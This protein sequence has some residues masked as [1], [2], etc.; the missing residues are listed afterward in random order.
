MYFNSSCSRVWLGTSTTSLSCIFLNSTHP[1]HVLIADGVPWGPVCQPSQRI[2]VKTSAPSSKSMSAGVLNSG[3]AN[4]RSDIWSHLRETG[5]GCRRRSLAIFLRMYACTPIFSASSSTPETWNHTE[6]RIGVVIPPTPSTITFFLLRYTH[7]CW[8]NRSCTNEVEDPGSIR[9]L[10]TVL[11]PSGAET[12]T[13]QVIN[14]TCSLTLRAT[15]W[16]SSLPSAF[17]GFFCVKLSACLCNKVQLY[18]GVLCISCT[19][20]AEA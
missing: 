11:D 18:D 19:S 2:L 14:R 20:I 8:A 15:T 7:K 12:F 10:A 16:A 3:S 6:P 17:S 9:P 1:R 4:Y 5:I 13:L